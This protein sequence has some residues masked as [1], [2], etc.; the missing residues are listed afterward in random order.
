MPGSPTRRK[1]SAP[2]VQPSRLSVHHAGV[3][4]CPAP[5]PRG[6]SPA[7]GAPR[8]RAAVSPCTLRRAGVGFELS[9][10][11]LPNFQREP[12]LSL[13]VESMRS[14]E[15]APYPCRHQIDADCEDQ[16]AKDAVDSTDRIFIEG[17]R[18]HIGIAE[19]YP[20]EQAQREKSR[21]VAGVVHGG[22]PVGD[23]SDCQA[24]RA[25]SAQ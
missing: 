23:E 14:E 24:H 17:A 7:R 8:T 25:R 13:G 4:Q 21:K 16:E 3:R 15:A 10:I 6:D 12:D 9:E 2:C 11:R 5:P 22:L 20:R 19:T 18:E 1:R